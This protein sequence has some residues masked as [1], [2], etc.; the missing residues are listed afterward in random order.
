MNS[1][2]NS[3]TSET[4]YQN[5]GLAYFSSI[6]NQQK[7]ITLDKWAYM[8][9]EETANYFNAIQGK[10]Y[11]NNSK[12][13]HLEFLAGYAT[14]EKCTKSKPTLKF[15]EDM[16]GQAALSRKCIIRKAENNSLFIFK[17]GTIQI[18]AK[19]IVILPLCTD[20]TNACGVIELIFHKEPNDE[21]IDF[22]KNLSFHIG[23]NLKIR[24]QEEELT[25]RNK[26]LQQKNNMIT[27]S[28]KYAQSIQEAILPHSEDIKKIFSDFFVIYQPKDIVSGDFYWMSQTITNKKSSK[29]I[30]SCIDCTGHGVPGAFMSMIGNTLL[31]ELVNE[32]QIYTPAQIMYNLHKG[33]Q[34]TLRQEENNNKDGMDLILCNL[35]YRENQN[36]NMIF[37]GAK[38]NLLIIKNSELIELKGDRTSIGGNQNVKEITFSNQKIRLKKGDLIYLTTD[39]YEDSPNQKRKKFGYKQLKNLLH[40]NSKLDLKS[41]KYELMKQLNEHLNGSLQRDDITIIGIRL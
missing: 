16:I 29:I 17:T 38:R 33:I 41:Q 14:L 18:N 20:T 26:E 8:I 4:N 35:D 10:F 6:I 27:G 36:I 9:L 24:L 22:L 19:A 5:I 7:L 23:S 1:T 40:L 32:K 21:E 34:N 12:K 11:V 30:F 2:S 25:Q 39:G 13:N 37:A 3:N 28:I 15:G 31:H